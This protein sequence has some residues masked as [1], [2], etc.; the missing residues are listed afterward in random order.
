MIRDGGASVIFGWTYNQCKPNDVIWNQNYGHIGT[1]IPYATGAML[2]DIAETGVTRPGMLVTSDSSFLFHIAELEVAVRRNLPLVCI[3]AVDFQWGLEV[4]V[5]KRTFGLGTAETGTHW[6]DKVRFDKIA[7]G[8]GAHGE[9]VKTAEEI[10]PA[11][12]R[13]YARGGPTVIHVPI[14]PKANSEEM[15]KYEKFR[16]WYAEG[17]Q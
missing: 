16:T 17:T 4:G 13:A 15:P 5:Y 2:A 11:I 6:S 8:L 3:V 1:G 14:D 10:G 12:A 9:F 7:E